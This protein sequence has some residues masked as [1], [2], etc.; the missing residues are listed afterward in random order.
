MS[1][2]SEI[3]TLQNPPPF[4]QPCEQQPDNDQPCEQQP[5]A[6]VMIANQQNAEASSLP[7]PLNG[8]QPDQPLLS[9]VEFH[10]DG[11]FILSTLNSDV[12]D[13]D[14][15]DGSRG[16]RS[17]LEAYAPNGGGS[18]SSF[19]SSMKQMG[20]VVMEN[21]NHREKDVSHVGSSSASGGP[22]G[23]SAHKQAKRERRQKAKAGD[24]EGA[25]AGSMSNSGLEGSNMQEILPPPVT[26]AQ[27]RKERRSSNEWVAPLINL[28]GGSQSLENK[29]GTNPIVAN[30]IT[31]KH[32]TN[33]SKRN[34]LRSGKRNLM[35]SWC[36]N[37]HTQQQDNKISKW[38]DLVPANSSV[39]GGALSP[40]VSVVLSPTLSVGDYAGSQSSL[41]HSNTL[42]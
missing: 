3:P 26:T 25:I 36:N 27:C 8:L 6:P 11:E 10:S 21:E 32:P 13:S 5:D 9:I 7:F 40:L 42:E 30:N 1:T 4:A 20:E 29:D 15:E 31:K 33:N 16:G 24:A 22:V 38:I 12:W 37:V 41:V 18:M 14:P 35:S 39:G 34:D 23:R 28:M 19:G 17:T 2:G